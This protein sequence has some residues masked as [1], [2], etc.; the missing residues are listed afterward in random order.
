MAPITFWRECLLQI[1]MPDEER[2][3]DRRVR[4]GR[5]R[6]RFTITEKAVLRRLS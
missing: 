4:K 2:Q 6:S 5:Y 3:I 1:P